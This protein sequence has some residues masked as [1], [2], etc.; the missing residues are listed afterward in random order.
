MRSERLSVYE[1][2]DST[3]PLANEFLRGMQVIESGES[4]SGAKR[5]TTGQGRHGA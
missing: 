3:D 2:W 4:K 1:Q 5:F